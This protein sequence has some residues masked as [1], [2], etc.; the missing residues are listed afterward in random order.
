M[1]GLIFYSGHLLKRAGGPSSYLYNLM[2]GLRALKCND[3]FFLTLDYIDGHKKSHKKNFKNIFKETLFKLGFIFPKEIAFFYTF[4]RKKYKH[5]LLNALIKKY[6]NNFDFIHF[7]TTVDFIDLKI[8]NSKIKILTTH[9]PIP[10]HLEI[11]DH[12]ANKYNDKLAKFF[13][14]AERR[15][16]E[17]AFLSADV[18]IFPA[19]ESLEGYFNTWQEFKNIIEG[20]KILFIPSGAASLEIKES[21]EVVRKRYNIPP[22]AFVVSYVGRHHPIKGYDILQRAADY[23][24]ARNFNLY[25]LIAG[26]PLPLKGLSD[27]R[28]IEVGWTENPGDYLNASDIFVLPNRKTYFDLVLIEALSLGKPIIA[29]NTGGNK[30]VARQTEGVI[31]FQNGDYVDLAKKILEVYKNRRHLKELGKRNLQLYLNFYTPEKFALRYVQ[32][33][34]EL[35]TII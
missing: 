23:L 4:L 28:W 27:K 24:W 29:S 26:L 31:L 3:I 5:N 9:S 34:E 2:T 20:K 1:K 12:I 11:E 15:I 32:G 25:F 8:I 10:P 35:L 19:V 30:F 16:D 13:K 7:H 14:E 22:D 33:L 17:Q 18:L 6:S 21:P